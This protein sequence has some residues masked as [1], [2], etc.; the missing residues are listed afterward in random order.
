MEV[1]G[2]PYDDAYELSMFAKYE[3]F[4]VLGT[5]PRKDSIAIGEK[6][7]KMDVECRLVPHQLRYGEWKCPDV[8]PNFNLDSQDM[9][10]AEL[11]S[12]MEMQYSHDQNLESFMGEEKDQQ[13]DHPDTYSLSS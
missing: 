13:K 5:W 1:I 11:S 7:R 3:S 9:I 12:L 8:V 4:S 10:D 6:L 2:I